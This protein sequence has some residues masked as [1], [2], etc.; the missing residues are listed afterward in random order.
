MVLS[1][2]IRQ[3]L[4]K[5]SRTVQPPDIA[6]I[7]VVGRVQEKIPE[8]IKFSSAASSDQRVLEWNLQSEVIPRTVKAPEWVPLLV[9][10]EVCTAVILDKGITQCGGREGE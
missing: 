5:S 1:I 6:P 10:E 2:D 9:I 8:E 3:S 4:S 7:R